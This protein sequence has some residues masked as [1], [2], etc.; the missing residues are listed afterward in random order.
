MWSHL[1]GLT[2]KAQQ[3]ATNLLEAAAEEY[4][5]EDEVNIT[6][7][8]CQMPSMA[9]QRAPLDL[10]PGTAGCAVGLRPCGSAAAAKVGNCRSYTFASLRTS[11]T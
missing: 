9:Q 1:N 6:H 11:H 8:D 2:S 5:D 7:V 3:L 4:D 10:L